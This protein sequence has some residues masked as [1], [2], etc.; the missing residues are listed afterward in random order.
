M[1]APN[2]L[3]QVG[4]DVTEAVIVGIG[5]TVITF[6]AV[7]LQVVVVVVTNAISSMAKSFPFEITVRS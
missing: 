7:K 2:G 1:I 5:V 3:V 6:E 4:A